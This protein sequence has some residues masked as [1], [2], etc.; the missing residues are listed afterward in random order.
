MQRPVRVTSPVLP[1]SPGRKKLP[2]PT[3]LSQR[4]ARNLAYLQ[5]RQHITPLDTQNLVIARSGRKRL[6]NGAFYDPHE[7]HFGV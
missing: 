5:A 4:T 6:F 7:S 2:Q 3:I 1:A